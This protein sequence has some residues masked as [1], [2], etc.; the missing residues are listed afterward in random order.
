MCV[1]QIKHFYSRIP[2]LSHCSLSLPHADFLLLFSWH[3]SLNN[4]TLT[5]AERERGNGNEASPS[6]APSCIIAHWLVGSGRSNAVSALCIDEN[7]DDDIGRT[8]QKTREYYHA[9][10]REGRIDARI[11]SEKISRERERKREQAQTRERERG[12]RKK[13][14]ERRRRRRYSHI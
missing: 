11:K 14:R 13:E 12:E 6:A 3:F 1:D 7:D 10:A 8:Y 9:F 2:A 4:G 5:S